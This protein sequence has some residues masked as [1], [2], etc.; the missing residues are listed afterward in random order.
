MTGKGK[1]VLVKG[2]GLGSGVVLAWAWNSL[3]PESSMPSE[4]ASALGGALMFLAAW[5]DDIVRDAVK[6]H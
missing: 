1:S 5:V 4:V 3:F 2:T 6:D